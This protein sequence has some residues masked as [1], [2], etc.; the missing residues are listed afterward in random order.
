MCNTSVWKCKYFSKTNDKNVENLFVYFKNS[1]NK[2]Y[3]ELLTLLTKLKWKYISK[4]NDKNVENLFVYFKNSFNK[5]YNELLTL[6][7]M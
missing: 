2:P 5:P 4:T 6:L 1:F 3:N 7:T